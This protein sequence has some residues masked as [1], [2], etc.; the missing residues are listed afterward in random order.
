MARLGLGLAALGRPGYITIGHGT[1]VG[2]SRDRDTMER[3]AHVVLDAAY[4]AGVRYF[5]AARSYGLAEA[6]LASWL[7]RREVVIGDVT[8]ASKWGYTY[9]ANWQVDA[10]VH[11]VK[12]HSLSV[13]RRQL[14]ESREQ[15]GDHLAIYQ[16]H[17]ATLE[18]GVLDDAAVIDALSEARASGL[19]IGLTV[20]GPRQADTILRALEIRRGGD[21]VFDTVQA[22]WNLLERGAEAALVAAH[23]AGV[24]VIVKE[25]VANGRLTARGVSGLPP[26]AR[27]A[28]VR[29]AATLG[30][31]EDAVAIACALSRPWVDVVLSGATTV[32][33]VESNLRATSL[34]VSDSTMERLDDLVTDSAT[35]WRERASLPWN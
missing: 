5:D 24:G 16:I 33:Q 20:S 4:D 6:F 35:Y 22:T 34:A 28:L 13:F 2:S 27:N 7:D 23:S 31:S 17:S 30:V 18:S 8:V 10:A 19:R 29:E 3:A 25:A 12:D 26:I 11:E 9:T 15:L 21:R 1:D 14:A 32:P